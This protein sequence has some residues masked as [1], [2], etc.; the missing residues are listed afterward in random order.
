MALTLTGTAGQT[1]SL[2]LTD[3][4][5][6]NTIT[7][8]LAGS[9]TV[10]TAPANIPANTSDSNWN[11]GQIYSTSI[12]RSTLSLTTSNTTLTWASIGNALCQTGAC[13]KVNVLYIKNLGAEAIQASWSSKLN[14]GTA[15]ST[16]DYFVV[17][18]YGIAMFSVPMDGLAVSGTNGLTLKTAANTTS[19]YV[20]I[21]HK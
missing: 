19:A 11:T 10:A 20:V 4:D 5:I 2:V 13:T 17:P 7:V 21:A 18:A 15:N 14:S 1:G 16:T 12:Y 3:T 9:M 6:N 8:S